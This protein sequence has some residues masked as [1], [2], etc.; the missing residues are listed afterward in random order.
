ME[1]TG[2]KISSIGIDRQGLQGLKAA[3]WNHRPARLYEFALARGEGKIA[4]NGAFVVKTGKHTGRSAQ[5][6]FIVRDEVTQDTVWWDNNRA[7]TPAQFAALHQDMLAH[8][9][10]REMFIQDLFGG[11]DPTH[12][13]PTR[14]IT[15]L[16]WHSLFI[17][18][19][20]IE[21]FITLW[22]N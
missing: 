1:Q 13:L 14:I 16:A 2:S 3:H 6:K 12:R 19:L 10:G 15:E 20:L 11:A 17:Q 5:D 21:Q 4:A 9:K 8:A 7:I 18:N 22:L